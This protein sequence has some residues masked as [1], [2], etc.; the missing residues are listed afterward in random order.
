[1]IA[2]IGFFIT[3]GFFSEHKIISGIISILFYLIY[4]LIRHSIIKE[5]RGEIELTKFAHTFYRLSIFTNI[6][7]WIIAANIK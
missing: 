4:L 7:I 1:M 6:L 5:K 2:W 3:I